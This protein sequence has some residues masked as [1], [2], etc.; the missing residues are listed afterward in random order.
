MAK[1]RKTCDNCGT[2]TGCRTIICKKCDTPF[3]FSGVSAPKR[4]DLIENWKDLAHEQLVHVLKG[5]G[6]RWMYHDEERE[7]PYENLGYS[8]IFRV[9]KVVEDGFYAYPVKATESGIC[10]I[11]MGE[12]QPSQIDDNLIQRP[13]TLRTVRIKRRKKK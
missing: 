5:S 3:K 7:T 11:Y 2:V 13:H 9:H 4:G 10:F 12:E 8:G 1:G 6:P